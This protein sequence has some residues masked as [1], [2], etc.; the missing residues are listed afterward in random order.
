[1]ILVQDAAIAS[2]RSRAKRTAKRIANDPRRQQA[3]IHGQAEK[4][5]LSPC[6]GF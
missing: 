6:A 2:V 1:V 5:G 3:Q 4:P